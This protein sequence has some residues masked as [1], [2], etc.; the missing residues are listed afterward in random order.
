M[1]DYFQALFLNQEL[2]P[3]LSWV[4]ELPWTR[5]FVHTACSLFLTGSSTV[6]MP[7]LSYHC[8]LAVGG[9]DNMSPQFLGLLI[10]GIKEVYFKESLHTWI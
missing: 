6:V 4:S 7:G 1:K 3:V 9:V 2:Q 5:D 8:M 10:N